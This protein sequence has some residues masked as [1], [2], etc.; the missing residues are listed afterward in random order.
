MLQ[1]NAA[2]LG[3]DWLIGNSRQPA[4]LW[5]ERCATGY[6][7]KF[8]RLGASVW[9]STL[10]GGRSA[11]CPFPDGSAGIVRT[12]GYSSVSAMAVDRKGSVT[13]AGA[14]DASDFP[15]TPG[16]D[17]TSGYYRAGFQGGA[18]SC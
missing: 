10:L 2:K 9:Y 5:I 17:T 14:T 18:M 1:A 8:A 7:M 13:V 12:L 15:V 16:A 11:I 3:I 6:V 4:C